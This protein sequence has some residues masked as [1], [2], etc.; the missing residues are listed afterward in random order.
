VIPLRDTLTRRSF[1]LVTWLLVAANSAVFLREITLPPAE[2]ERVVERFALVPA[3]AGTIV[4]FFTSMFL[5]GGWMH[6]IGNLWTLWIFGDN[7]EERMGPAR[8]LAFYLLTGLVGGVAHVIANVGSEVPTMGASGAI[9][10][11]LGAYLFLFPR[12]KI[13][14]LV[15]IFFW[16]LFLQVPAVFYLLFW[17][18]TQVFG[19]TIAGVDPQSS[20]GIAYWAHIGG[21]GAGAILHRAFLLRRPARVYQYRS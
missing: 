3:R 4:P 2:L 20:G 5:H 10:G 19:G 15:P 17:F 12:A 9:A 11:V 21:F 8:Y 18:A 16:P 13:V 14:T 6:V 1:P 7:V